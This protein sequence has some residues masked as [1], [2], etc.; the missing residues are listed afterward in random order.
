MKFVEKRPSKKYNCM[1][2]FLFLQSG[3][4][5]RSF[6]SGPENPDLFVGQPPLPVSTSP[7]RL[8]GGGED[9]VLPFVGTN[10]QANKIL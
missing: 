9:I 6:R 5:G 2:F 10:K 4:A 8:V 3:G 1:F 7:E